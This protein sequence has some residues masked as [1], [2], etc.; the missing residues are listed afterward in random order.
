MEERSAIVRSHSTWV[1]WALL[2]FGC[3]GNAVGIAW[4]A[5]AG[6]L[7]WHSGE[8]LLVV[9]F[10]AFLVVG[11]LLLARRPGNT[12]GWIF[13]A[14]GLLTMLAGLAETYAKVGHAHPGSLPDP[15]VAA[16]VL[17]WIWNPIVM[18]TVCSRCC[19][20]DR[21]VAVVRLAAGD[22]A[23]GWPDGGGDAARRAPPVD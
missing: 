12:I 6:T 1:A 11:C 7:A 4:G 19:C 22:L 3:V 14:V 23:G 9:V 21:P 17:D 16:W 8:A 13:T 20:S 15:L 18:L 5:A 10:G 2:A